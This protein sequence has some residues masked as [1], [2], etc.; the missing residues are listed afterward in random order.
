MEPRAI[1]DA[2]FQLASAQL[3]TSFVTNAEVATHTAALVRSSVKGPLRVVLSCLLAKEHRPA[4]DVRKPYS[5]LGG[6][7]SF[8]GRTYDEGY[9]TKFVDEHRFK[10]TRTTGFLS[11]AF[12][13]KNVVLTVSLNLGGSPAA[14]YRA[15]LQL[16]DAVYSG[17]ETPSL[18]LAEL[19]RLLV[20]QR[21][22]AE[23]ELKSKL[24]SLRSLESESSLSLSSE[25]IVK[26]IEGQFGIGGA[27][28]LPVLLV[29]AAYQAVGERL[30]EQPLPL[31][32]HNAADSQTGSLGDVEIRLTNE[33]KVVTAY[34]MKLKRVTEGD[35]DTALVK[36]TNGA[37]V[38]NYIFI[39]TEPIDAH[40]ALKA[41]RLYSTFGVEFA[42]LNCI[43]FIRHF[44]H[45][46]H[47]NRIE[48]LEKYQTLLLA[49]PE[50]TVSTEQKDYWLTARITAETQI[51]NEHI[52]R[53]A[54][55]FGS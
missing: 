32:A 52:Q 44:L 24:Q 2:A 15:A 35:I 39:T 37:R 46:F 18:V 23:Q 54:E 8:S 12:R 5:E 30:G 29:A 45:F 11:P 47:R 53:Q 3:A 20:L 31:Q 41:E 48:F 10:V 6:T 50:N 42:I 9:I 21:D 33:D 26:L 14:L 17:V 22:K 25:R 40:V 36:L 55:L 13:T 43:G 7:D 51:N 38:D 27:S 1:L 4:V 16:L 49:E 28:R 34:E 19:T